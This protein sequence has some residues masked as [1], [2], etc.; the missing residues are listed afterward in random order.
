MPCDF[1]AISHLAACYSMQLYVEKHSI[2][3]HMHAYVSVSMHTYADVRTCLRMRMRAYVC[4]CM[5]M[6][7]YVWIR[8][9]IRVPPKP[10]T[11]LSH[12]STITVSY[13]SRSGSGHFG[14]SGWASKTYHRV[15]SYLNYNC[16]IFFQIWIIA[17]LSIWVGLPNLPQSY[18]IPPLSLSHPL[19]DLDRGISEHLD[20]P[21]KP[22]TK[23]SH[24]CII[25]VSYS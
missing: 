25:A 5:H 16:V 17:F 7:S 11:A 2:F 21:T 22:T 13:S 15:I 18:L 20:V 9:Q 12:T 14:A 19:P 1:I 3:V 10:T 8:M 6:C 24:T 4:I 23:L